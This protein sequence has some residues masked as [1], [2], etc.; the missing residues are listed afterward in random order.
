MLSIWYSASIIRVAPINHLKSLILQRSSFL[1]LILVIPLHIL[2]LLSNRVIFPFNI[3]WD[4]IDV[5]FLI[6]FLHLVYIFK[7]L[8]L[9]PDRKIILCT[10]LII[11]LIS[12][13][14][15]V[16]VALNVLL[17]NFLLHSCHALLHLNFSIYRHKNLLIFTFFFIST[18]PFNVFTSFLN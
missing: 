12:S 8:N 17:I 3:L 18:Y 7:V 5:F 1:S 6:I 2:I 13:N 4:C 16:D 15:I 14:L 10:N 9:T 11:S